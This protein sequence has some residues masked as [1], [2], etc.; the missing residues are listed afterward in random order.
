MS[1]LPDRVSHHMSHSPETQTSSQT[2]QGPL[3]RLLGK[4]ARGAPGG[5][6][7]QAVW[8]EAVIADSEDTV[9]VEGNHH[10]PPEA[11]DA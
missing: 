8:N 2:P 6:R 3:R 4:L 10:F 7:M 5:S 9:V 1:P 11:V